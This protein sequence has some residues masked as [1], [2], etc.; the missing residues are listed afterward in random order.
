MFFFGKLCTKYYDYLDLI[1]TDFMKSRHRR[2]SKCGVEKLEKSSTF[3]MKLFCKQHK[4]IANISVKR[5]QSAVPRRNIFFASYSVNLSLF[6]EF[7][8][9]F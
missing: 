2:V 7:L 1:G 4:K 5:L 3:Y 8:K 6:M 9:T